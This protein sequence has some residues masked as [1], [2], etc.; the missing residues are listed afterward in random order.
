MVQSI[1]SSP[2]DAL[3]GQFHLQFFDG[4]SYGRQLQ[5]L[6]AVVMFGLY[7]LCISNPT[8]SV[9]LAVCGGLELCLSTFV[10]DFKF[11]FV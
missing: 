4:C 3:H 11:T 8:S 2:T 1:C 6:V 5:P 10:G 9:S 7:R